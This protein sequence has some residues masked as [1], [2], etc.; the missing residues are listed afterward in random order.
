[1]YAEITE[2]ALV[3]LVRTFYAKVRR[4]PMIGPVFN[5]A[6]ED[7]DEHLVTLTGFWSSVMLGTGRYKG[8]P[9]GAHQKQPIKPEMFE[10]WLSLWSETVGEMFEPKA[11]D[12][13]RERAGRIGESLRQ[14]LFFRIPA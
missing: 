7:W 13:L 14:G 9:F 1:M 8:N 4:D 11:A 3:E 12:Q 5:A 10:R 6:V 2:T